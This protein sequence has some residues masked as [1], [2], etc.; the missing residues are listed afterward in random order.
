MQPPGT[1]QTYISSGPKS[2]T[3]GIY[4]RVMWRL[5]EMAVLDAVLTK[6]VIDNAQSLQWTSYIDTQRIRSRLTT[7]SPCMSSSIRHDMR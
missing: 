2:V 7:P 6:L 1:I 3:S 5:V 4:F